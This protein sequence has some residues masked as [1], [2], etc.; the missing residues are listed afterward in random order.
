MEETRGHLE[1]LG[2]EEEPGGDSEAEDVGVGAAGAGG[3]AAAQKQKKNR[4]NRRKGKGK[5]AGVELEDMDDA[6][7]KR[8]APLSC[9][10]PALPPLRAL[11]T[12]VRFP[13]LR[14]RGARGSEFLARATTG[15]ADDPRWMRSGG[16]GIAAPAGAAGL[17]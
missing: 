12:G 13:R 8:P 11:A 4:N 7:T 6:V 3:E 5:P 9:W 17:E 14:A 2:G 1:E 15:N 10:Q 16:A